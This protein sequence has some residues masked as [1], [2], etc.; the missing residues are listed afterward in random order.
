MSETIAFKPEVLEQVNKIIARY[1]E[2]RQKS[3][4]IPVLH[5][6]Q[7]EFSGWLDVPVM[8]YVASL[9]DIRPIE[10]YEVATF[11][12]MFNMKPVGKY[13]LEVCRT[14]PCMLKGS[15]DILDYIRQK[16]NIKDGETTEDGLFTLKPAECLGA[17]GYAPM[18]QLGK[19]YHENL[20]KEKVD[21]ILELCRQGAVALD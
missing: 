4:L 2:G 7:K 9:L 14:G 12:T 3:A 15:D 8:D 10:V 6:A 5:I 17:C 19:F 16:L 11:Y 20:T 18:M 21:E 13:V 1:P